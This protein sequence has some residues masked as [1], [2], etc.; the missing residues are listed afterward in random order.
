MILTKQ[1][2]VNYF[3]RATEVTTKYV[4]GSTYGVV[5]VWGDNLL[6][7]HIYLLENKQH[8]C[9]FGDAETERRINYSDQEFY[10]LSQ[11]SYS[12]NSQRLK[13]KRQKE[14]KMGFLQLDSTPK[15]LPRFDLDLRAGRFFAVE[16][17][18]GADGDWTSNKVEV[19]NPVFVM[20]IA[21]TAIGWTAFIDNRPD[22]VMHH[23]EDGMPKQPSLEHKQSFETVIQLVGGDFDGSVR[24]FGKGGFTIGKAFDDLVDSWLASSPNNKKKK[25]PVVSVTGS[26][27]VK[28]GKSTNYAPEWSITD[29][30]DRPEEFDNWI[31][32]RVDETTEDAADNKDL[33]F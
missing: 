7:Y 32:P 27:A 18:Q 17:V 11:K 8:Q 12:F 10:S 14:K 2:K 5:V 26:I 30:V 25:C 21:N 1:H 20:D 6:P 9:I 33:P 19:E 16:R 13:V 29:W 28:A 24:K 4:L 23:Q 31:P 15:F 3:D 22:S